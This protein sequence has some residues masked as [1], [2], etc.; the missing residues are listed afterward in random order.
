MS[1]LPEI[2][3]RP[4]LLSVFLILLTTFL[5]FVILGPLIGIFLALPFYEN[6]FLDLIEK[7]ENPTAH[8]EIKIALTI[9]QGSATFIGLAVIPALYLKGIERKSVF[10]L[11]S[12]KDFYPI[13]AAVTALLVISF[14]ITNSV[15]IDWNYH[16]SFPEFLKGFEKWAREYENRAEQLTKFF[17]QFNTTGEFLVG[18]LVIAVLPAM[19]EELVFRGMLQNEL[20]RASK[21]HHIAIWTSAILFSA[22]HMQFFGFVPRMLLGAL[23][24]YLYV[25]S[26]NLLMPIIAHFVNNGFSVLMLYLSKLKITDM[27]MESPE[28]A[29]LPAILI[30]TAIFGA[31]LLYYKN[32]YQT[33]N[34]NP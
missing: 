27:D 34:I 3:Q 25:W 21:N 33:R 1:D 18:L 2:S 28:A 30:F 32:F 22:F 31:L 16:L 6:G 26:G 29:P 20:Y 15:F 24:G 19:G 5:G 13:M 17:T 9:L 11:F 8:P 4:P 10:I 14:M 7:L 12:K 23:F